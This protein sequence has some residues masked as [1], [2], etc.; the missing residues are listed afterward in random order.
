MDAFVMF[1]LA[2]M[3]SILVFL[4]FWILVLIFKI[5]IKLK[6]NLIGVKIGLGMGLLSSSLIY[7]ICMACGI[8][9][10]VPK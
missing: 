4:C 8:Y 5:N 2:G 7:L 3:A 10:S 1:M 6:I 9:F